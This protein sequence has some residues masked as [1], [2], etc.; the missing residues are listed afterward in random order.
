MKKDCKFRYL[1]DM[2]GNW[3]LYPPTHVQDVGETPGELLSLLETVLSHSSDIFV[4]TRVDLEM[5][6][7]RES[8][9]GRDVGRKKYEIERLVYSG[10]GSGLNRGDGF[11]GMGLVN[12]ISLHLDNIRSYESF[13]EIDHIVIHNIVMEGKTKIKMYG[14]NGG[15]EEIWLYP[16]HSEN[17]SPVYEQGLAI[18]MYTLFPKDYRIAID[19]YSTIFLE[20][21]KYNVGCEEIERLNAFRLR[22]YLKTIEKVLGAEI[23]DWSSESAGG[24]LI[25]KYGFRVKGE[26]E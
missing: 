13:K 5:S 3:L 16:G 14:E 23:A 19:A 24:G 4:P 26:P 20:E 8:E 1:D 2:V 25:Y 17:L 21:S 9:N 11:T 7:F 12:L 18:R 10:L 6:K 15:I 22:D